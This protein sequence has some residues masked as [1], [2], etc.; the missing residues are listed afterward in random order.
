MGRHGALRDRIRCI[1]ANRFAPTCR[2]PDGRED[3][4]DEGRQHAEQRTIG[5]PEPACRERGDERAHAADDCLGRAAE[6]NLQV[7]SRVA[8]Q[9]RERK[10]LGCDHW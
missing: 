8:A 7:A 2:A 1:R 9:R 5:R 6:R 3:G 4:G 10:N